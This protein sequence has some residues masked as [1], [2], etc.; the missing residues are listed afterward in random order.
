M[1]VE[2]SGSERFAFEYGDDFGSHIESFD[3]DWIKALV[4]FN[5]A[6]PAEMQDAQIASLRRLNDWVVGAR[7]NWMLELLVPATRS[8]LAAHED[9]SGYDLHLRPSL[10]VEVIST[11]AAGGVHPSIWK[12]EGYENADGA[13]EVLR[14]VDATGVPCCCIVLGRDA[15]RDKV[16]HW[17]D[18]AAPLQGYAG[19]AIGRSNWEEPLADYLGGR[20]DRETTEARIAERYGHFVERFIRAE[21]MPMTLAGQPE[22]FTYDHPRL[23]P[24]REETIRQAVQG[25]DPQAELPAWMVLSLLAEV[26]ALPRRP[27]TRACSCTPDGGSPSAGVR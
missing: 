6:D 11:L 12:L 16:D 8:Q 5:P 23:T 21:A 14:A 20:A 15:P 2:V 22:P 25:S 18:V 13:R 27:V 1:P 9:Q 19:F 26:D 10:T 3:P 17:L 7:R 24:E 4:R